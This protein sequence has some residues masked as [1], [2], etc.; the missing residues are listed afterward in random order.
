MGESESLGSGSVSGAQPARG[1][2]EAFSDELAMLRGLCPM[3]AVRW[4]ETWAVGGCVAGRSLVAWVW[5]VW[6][7]SVCWLAL[8]P[9]RGALP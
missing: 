2:S 1:P 8:L 4:L 3:A 9:R 7:W 5:H 6:R